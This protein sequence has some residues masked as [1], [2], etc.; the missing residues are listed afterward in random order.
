MTADSPTSPSGARPRPRPRPHVTVVATGVANLASVLAGLGRAGAGTSVTDDAEMVEAATHLVLPG[1]GS[2]AAAMESLA[3]RELIEPLRRRIDAG[4]PTLAICLGMQVLFAASD[5]SPGVAGL[6]C[7]AGTMTRFNGG[8]RV[9]QLG[10]NSIEP[11]SDC[12]FLRAGSVY[13][14]NSYRLASEPDGDWACAGA[15][16]GGRFVAALERR[17][18]LACQFHPELSG[19]FG[20]DLIARWLDTSADRSAEPASD[21]RGAS[22]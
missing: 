1:V 7:I 14:A 20:R 9:P 21:R 18:V 22:C 3:A 4:R 16:H 17:G 5:E 10:W 11:A 6:G 2:F 13:F 8:V 12:R 15:D 19:R